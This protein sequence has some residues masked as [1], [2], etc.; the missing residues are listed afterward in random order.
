MLEKCKY[1]LVFEHGLLYL[2]TGEM[3]WDYQMHV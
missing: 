1:A 2:T 3:A